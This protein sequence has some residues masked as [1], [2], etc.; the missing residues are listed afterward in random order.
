MEVDLRPVEGAVPRVDL[1]GQPAVVERPRQRPLGAVPQ[2]VRADPLRRPGGQLDPHV[3][4]AERPVDLED[5]LGDRQHL[6]LDLTFGAEDVGVVLRE[7]AHPEEAVGDAAALVAVQ[8]AEVRVADRQVAVRPQPGREDQAVRRAVHRLHRHLP[9]VGLGEEHVLA[10]VVV[11]P[12]GLPHLDVED[13]RRDHLAVAVA[14]VEAAHVV[15]QRDVDRAPLGVEEGHRRRQRIEAEEVELRPQPAVVARPGQLDLRQVLV[16]LLLGGEGGAVDALQALV[17]LVPLPVDGGGLE[18]LDRAHLRQ[19]AHVR[20]P[21]EVGEAAVAVEGDRLPRR[22]VLQA[23]DLQRLPHLA[24]DPLGLLAGDLDALELAPLG[25]DLPHL[26]LDPLEVLGGE[27]AREAEVVLE[28]LAVVLAPGVD[29]RL[30]PE[31]LDRVGQH[32]LGAVADELA[33][34]RALDGEDAE[35][36]PGLERQAQVDLAAVELGAHGVLGQPGTD[37]GGHLERGGS[38]GHR[39]HGAVGQGQI[40]GFSHGLHQTIQK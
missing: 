20:A 22:D 25:E 12:R 2:L 11:V 9:L 36:S 39:A 17:G 8:P 3:L 5:H 13:L 38:G 23:L 35:R 30:R 7:G 24:E 28:L 16:H 32:V 37:R 21:A 19:A 33:G 26:R 18:Q 40:N 31:P 6:R 15:G 10:V 29:L 34:L 14:R 4:E 27:G 1:V